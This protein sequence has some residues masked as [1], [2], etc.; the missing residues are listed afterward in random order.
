VSEVA[1][2][3]DMEQLCQLVF[4]GIDSLSSFVFCGSILTAGSRFVRWMSG[5]EDVSRPE[6]VRISSKHASRM[7]MVID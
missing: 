1:D 6:K 2:I 3:L 5:T 7:H 4:K